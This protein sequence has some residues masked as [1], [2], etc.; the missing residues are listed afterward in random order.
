MILNPGNFISIF[1]RNKEIIF[2]ISILGFIYFSIVLISRCIHLFNNK[3]AII[4][5]NNFIEDNSSYKSFGKINWK[6]I[7]SIETK[8]TLG[9]NKY[10]EIKMK[11]DFIFFDTYKLNPL[12]KVLVFMKN[13]NYKSSIILTDK[14]LKISFD[15]FKS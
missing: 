14:F 1:F 4:I 12:Q 6:N 8:G 9:G 2:I 3:S 15:D 13:W 10:I 11:R 7:Q 5:S